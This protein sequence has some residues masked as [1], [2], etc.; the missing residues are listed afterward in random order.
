M[1]RAGTGGLAH[2]YL[3]AKYRTCMRVLQSLVPGSADGAEGRH[4]GGGRLT[5]YLTMFY[6]LRDV[7][8]GGELVFPLAD[9][10]VRTIPA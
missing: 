6:F 9:A 2:Q 1:E 3:P 4:A 7:P 5:R 10:E 8:E